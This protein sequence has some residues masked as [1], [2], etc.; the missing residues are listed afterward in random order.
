MKPAPA[1]KPVRRVEVVANIASGSVGPDAPDVAAKIFSDFGIE[2]NIC[3]PETSDL[4]NCLRR[5]ADADPD[6][7]V[8]IAGDGTARAA[9]EICGPD[10]PLLAPLPGGTMNI[11]PYAIYGVRPWQDA[12]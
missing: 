5:A 12:I 10:G 9:A 7:L 11:L 6:L 1:A 3:A 2:A 4:T 8:V